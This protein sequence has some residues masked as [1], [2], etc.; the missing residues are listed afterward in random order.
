MRVRA[1][2]LVVAP[3]SPGRARE[4]GLAVLARAL[5]ALI[6]VLAASQWAAGESMGGWCDEIVDPGSPTD[7]GC[8]FLDDG[9]YTAVRIVP[10]ALV[11]ISAL[12]AARWGR[13]GLVYVGFIVGALIVVLGI[14]V[15]P[16]DYPW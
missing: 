2:G 8:N 11:V 1:L 13:P 16:A 15:P 10:S 5:P 7:H 9:G 6:A 3:G 4:Y 12:L 14:T